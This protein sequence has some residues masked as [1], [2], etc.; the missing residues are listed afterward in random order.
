MRDIILFMLDISFMF[1]M[2][3][4]FFKMNFFKNYYK[5]TS[6]FNS[7]VPNNALSGSKVFDMVTRKQ[8]Q[9]TKNKFIYIR[10]NTLFA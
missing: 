1:L 8:H 6:V 2:S 9:Q 3:A 10:Y 7:L 4:D 5:I